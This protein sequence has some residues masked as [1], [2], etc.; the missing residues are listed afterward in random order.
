M[1]PEP[2]T[3]EAK[4]SG[5]GGGLRRMCLADREAVLFVSE[6][7]ER[8]ILLLYDLSGL[9]H[10]VDLVDSSLILLLR[11]NKKTDNPTI[12]FPVE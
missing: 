10:N 11:E 9:S 8:H 1:I 7:N 12:W 5:G 2:L 4:L 3:T 6:S